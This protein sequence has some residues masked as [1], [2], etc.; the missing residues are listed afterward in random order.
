MKSECKNSYLSVLTNEALIT[1]AIGVVLVIS[2]IG[3]SSFASA[4][5]RFGRADL[6]SVYQEATANDAQLAAA[7][8]QYKAHK[9]ITSQARAEL[10]PSLTAGTSVQ[11]IKVDQNASSFNHTRSDSIF[12]ASLNQPLFRADRWFQLEAAHASTAQAEL[13]LSAKEQSLILTAAEAYFQTLRA[14][15]MLAASKA[16]EAA[17]QRQQK[18]AQARLES[19]ASSI[20][21]TLDAQAAYDNAMANRK[22]AERKVDDAFGYLCRLTNRD[23]TSIEGIQ[24]Q[25]PLEAPVPNDV[26]TWVNQAVQE[27]LLLKASNF[28]VIAAEHIILQRKSGFAP[29]LDAV[30]SY[31]KGDGSSMGGS[32]YQGDVTQRSIGLELNIPLYSGG[33]TRSQVREATEQLSQSQ[34]EREDRLRGIVQSTR[35]LRRTVNSDIE[36]V[37]ARRQ[38]IRSSQASVHANK[39]GWEMGVR[40]VADVLNAQRQLYS[41]VREYNNA[42][43]DYIINTLKLKQAAGVLSPDDLSDLSIYL[44]KDYDSV[45]DFLPPDIRAPL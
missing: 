33:M 16:E 1:F 39:M 15:D 37:V 36:Q 34:Y 42:R 26:S 5:D 45:R 23:Y 17:M 38:S 32:N 44:A 41:V 6:L 4:N 13:E 7:R 20:T 19:G 28:S 22:L 2:L 29:T 8:H 43:Y 30:I 40:N 31:R 14:L 3:Y 27:N 11:S 10:L 12:Q 35:S 9:E 18:Q 21:D 25:L 24:H